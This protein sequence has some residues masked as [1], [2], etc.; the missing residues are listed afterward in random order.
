MHKIHSLFRILIQ[1]LSEP[2]PK[3]DLK[4]IVLSGKGKDEVNKQEM[5]LFFHFFRIGHI[6]LFE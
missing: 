4:F 5:N 1:V 3:T 2:N 6:D